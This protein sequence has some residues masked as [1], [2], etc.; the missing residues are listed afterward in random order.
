M[1][2]YYISIKQVHYKIKWSGKIIIDTD[3]VKIR[4]KL[5]NV[6][7]IRDQIGDKLDETPDILGRDVDRDLNMTLADLLPRVLMV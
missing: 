5:L 1:C 6:D 3:A 2:H 4:V 7:S